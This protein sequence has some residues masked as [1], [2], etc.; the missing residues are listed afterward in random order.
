M[1]FII[2]KWLIKAWGHIPRLFWAFWELPKIDQI[3]TLGPLILSPTYLKN[4]RKSHI[5]SKKYCFYISTNAG[6]PFFWKYPNRRAPKIVDESL[7][8]ILKI[9]DMR[10]ISTR[11]MNGILVGWY[12]CLPENM[13]LHFERMGLLSS[14]KI[15]TV[16]VGTDINE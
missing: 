10:S 2:P 3:W 14:N 6:L 13:K 12:Q 15:L 4:I 9:L 1:G 5:V 8:K 7:N 16:N 11:N